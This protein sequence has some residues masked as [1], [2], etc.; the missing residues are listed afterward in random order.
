MAEHTPTPWKRVPIDDGTVQSIINEERQRYCVNAFHSDDGR[1]IP[2]EKIEPG[3]YWKLL[4]YVGLVAA[5][6]TSKSL[7][8][9]AR[10]LL[11]KLED[12]GR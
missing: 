2:T 4:L 1:E 5:G 8:E 12:T 11:A 3:L 6:T 10:V 9:Q 7:R